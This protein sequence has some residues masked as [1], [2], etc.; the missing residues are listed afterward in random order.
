MKK[1]FILVLFFASLL[2]FSQTQTKI[3]YKKRIP[4]KGYHIK[5]KSVLQDSRC[6]ENVT[7]VWAGE[8]SVVVLVYNDKKFVVE[9]TIIFNTQNR[10]ENIKWFENYYCSKIKSISVLPYPKDGEIVDFKKKFI[11]LTFID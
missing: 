1:L 6:P 4:L 2:C 5:L 10:E 8:V 9:K 7:C 11:K 3:T